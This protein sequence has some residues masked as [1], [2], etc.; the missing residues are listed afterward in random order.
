M[1][2]F[3]AL[4]IPCVL[5]L[6][7]GAGL[8]GCGSYVS[9]P[10]VPPRIEQIDGSLSAAA[11]YLI[12]Q[13]QAD[14][15]WRPDT[16][17]AFKDGPS[18]TPLAVQALLACPTSETVK[19]ACDK[20]SSYLANLVRA[21]GTIDP[22]PREFSYPVYTSATAVLVL[23]HPA[24]VRHRQA[25]DAWLLY[26]RARQL[27][28]ELGWQERDREYGGWGYAA[29]L[30]RKPKPGEMAPL[31]T[32][33]NLSA[34]LFAL[35]ALR[36]AGCPASDPAFRKALTF[37]KRCQNFNDDPRL[38]DPAYDDGG[39]F[40]V[41]DDPVRNKAGV[42]GKD[43]TGHERYA[44]YGS[45]TVDGLRSLL[46]CGMPMTDARVRAARSWLE[47]HFSAVTH[48]GNYGPEKEE[49]RQAVYFYYCA[50]CA[51]LF[52]SLGLRTIETHSGE[53]PWAQAL[54]DQLMNQQ[55]DEGSWVNSA[56]AVREDEPV[57]ATSLALLAL[58]H[59]RTS[60]T[61]NVQ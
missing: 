61:G 17:G 12:A 40:F 19:Q 25:R 47:S 43:A 55:R 30:P 3:H 6:A 31:L 15:A 42:A 56:R 53:I 44:S 38:R 16:Y 37:I 10:S 59:C 27:T 46:A 7:G 4:W 39:F 48:P 13:Q 23:S 57:L 24:N 28:E 32:E 2:R 49:S 58:A 9:K 20:G 29:G 26:L 50:G 34:T 22:R 60:T 33:S 45:A 8:P 5:L 35:Q 1:N 41:Y 18:L 36:G 14:G 52:K 11:A 21:D 51:E 54:A